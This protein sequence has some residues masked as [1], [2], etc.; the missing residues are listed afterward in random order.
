[1]AFVLADLGF[2]LEADAHAEELLVQQ[3]G[4][5]RHVDPDDALR[6][7]AEQAV[8]PAHLLA[9]AALGGPH[10]D[11]GHPLAGLADVHPR[12]VAEGEEPLVE[13]GGG[14]VRQ[15]A[16]ALHLPELDAAEPL[17]VLHRLPRERVHRTRVPELHLVLRH[18]DQ[19]LVEGRPHE[20][21]R[22]HPLAGLPVQHAL[23]TPPAKPGPANRSDKVWHWHDMRRRLQLWHFP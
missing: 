3:L 11:V 14:A 20:H 21:Q 16:V 15:H 2:K 1:M 19:P 13:V 9:A 7:A 10:D 8:G 17:L 18:V 6:G 12:E 4:A 23:L 22:L 5:V